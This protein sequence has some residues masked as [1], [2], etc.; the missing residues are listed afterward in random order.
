MRIGEIA[1]VGPHHEEKH[2]FIKSIADNVEVDTR[3]L[4][5]GQFTV[6]DQLVLHLYGISLAENNQTVSWDLISQKLLGYVA[7][8]RWGDADSFRKV[9][10][11]VDDLTTRYH[12]KVVVAGHT[13]GRV[14]PLPR[15][16]EY[17]LP[18]DK[19]GAFIFC[20]VKNPASVR[21]VLIALIDLI[22]DQME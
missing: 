8:F 18:I 16:F 13:E 2:E 4:T 10:R 22:I 12:A 20:N 11:L 6:N 17:G 21:R 19:S 9:Q 7:I 15:A 1:I 14:P 3:N 5:F